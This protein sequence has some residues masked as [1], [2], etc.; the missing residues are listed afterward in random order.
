M[1]PSRP[2]GFASRSIVFVLLAALAG[3]LGLVLAQRVFSPMPE[4]PAPLALKSVRLIEPA[5]P[6][7]DFQLTRSDGSA[8][9][10]MQ[11]RGHWTLVF[12][13]FSHC[14]DV[15]PTTLASL[16]Q[17]QKAWEAV[18]EDH[19][20]RLLFVSV[21]P[22][23]DT[24]KALG[25]YAHFFHPATIAA[26][27]NEPALGEFAKALGLVYMKVPQANGDYDMDH[28]ATLVL[29]DPQGR[30]AGL[31]RPPLQAKDIAADITLLAERRP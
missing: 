31:V 7:A 19:R 2:R 26:T 23:R 28:S 15:C 17:A 29:L 25:D 22:E 13:G 8:L 14:P 27:A 3:G 4:T 24:P 10:A 9:T 18:A 6:I 30:Q 5:R 12:I 11:L 20:P 21:D 1:N 16:A